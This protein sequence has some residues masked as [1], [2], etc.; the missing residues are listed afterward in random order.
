MAEKLSRAEAERRLIGPGLPFELAELEIRGVKT[1]VWRHAPSHLGE[2]FAATAAHGDAEFIVYGKERLTY[3]QHFNK[4]CRFAHVLR[5]RYDIRKGDR[6]AIAMRNLPE[7]SVAFWGTV[8][9]GA[10][11]VPLNAWLT[12]R[13]LAYCLDHSGSSVAVVDGKRAETFAPYIDDL[14]LRGIIVAR[15]VDSLA[16]EGAASWVEL[17]ESAAD[18]ADPPNTP[19]S[20][21]DDATIFYTSGTT[22]APNGALGTHRN[23]CSNIMTAA[24]RSAMRQ[25]C[26]GL[27]P[28]VLGGE[29]FFATVLVPV[30]F[31]HVTGC[32][33]ILAPA[34]LGGA[35]VVLMHRWDPEKALAA[36]EREKV[37]SFV[38]VPGMALQL[39]ESPCFANH[40]TSS[41][42]NI[43]YGGAPAAPRLRQRLAERFP[44][45]D[46]ENG[47]GL[48]EASAVAT[49]I[50]GETYRA[51]PASVGRPIPTSEIKIIDENGVS[52]PAG[53]EGEICVKGPNVVRGYWR[54]RKTTA[55]TFKDGWMR[56]GDI[57][58][59]DNDGDLYV[60]DRVTDML[61]R[62]GENIHC[63]EVENALYSHPSVIEAAVVGK[64]HEILGQEVAAVVHVTAERRPSEQELIAH[65]RERLAPFKVPVLI[66][67][68]LER[69]P[70]N[71]NGK[72]V[73]HDLQ[74]EL[75]PD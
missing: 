60:L 74:M 39:A 43:G 41:L 50:A 3:A 8:S 5:E 73:K 31:F 34:V 16:V 14:N 26:R 32:H 29:R 27:T 72:I 9:L 38:G 6:V 69:L 37:T 2:V 67:I 47:Y 1:R 44:K 61:I 48:T 45:A 46:A 53:A 55:S 65:C 24:F 30:P 36:I 22:G 49:Y 58:L 40:D 64:P 11:A 57:G 35:K 70:S 51:K 42:I 19:M 28:A 12:G 18:S 59:I 7:W 54:D 23:I 4:V 56:T 21:E 52:L 63:I 62:G 25:L 33:A 10:I 15:S 71:A 68:R 75:F 66:D 20:S 17:V 13:D